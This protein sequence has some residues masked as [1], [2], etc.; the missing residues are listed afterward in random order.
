MKIKNIFLIINHNIEGGEGPEKYINKYI[1]KSINKMK[2]SILDI[3]K[4][5]NKIEYDWLG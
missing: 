2:I 5:I 4:K 1:N 3:I